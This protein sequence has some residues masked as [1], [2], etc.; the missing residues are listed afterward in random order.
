[1]V[2]DQGGDVEL[3]KRAKP[4]PQLDDNI[5]WH[6]IGDEDHLRVTI[7]I[8]QFVPVV[9]FIVDFHAMLPEDLEYMS[10]WLGAVPWPLSDPHAA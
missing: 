8:N 10:P 3:V 9:A 6:G 7:H 4:F 1:M 5:G 2:T